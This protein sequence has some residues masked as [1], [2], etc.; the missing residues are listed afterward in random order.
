MDS[1]GRRVC[2]ITPSILGGVGEYPRPVRVSRAGGEI[3]GTLQSIAPARHLV[4]VARFA[5]ECWR[6]TFVPCRNFSVC[7]R[8][9]VARQRRKSV[10]F[11]AGARRPNSLASALP[12]RQRISANASQQIVTGRPE[13]NNARF[14]QHQKNWHHQNFGNRN[15]RPAPRHTRRK[16]VSVRR[17]LP[18]WSG[19]ATNGTP[20][21]GR[22]LCGI[23][24]AA[25]PPTPYYHLTIVVLQACASWATWRSLGNGR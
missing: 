20:D 23:G 19:I 1:I 14:D 15:A 9:R 2:A 7:S 3:A 22:A 11:V 6:L 17:R 8:Q 4:P 18:R 5:P 25:P 16:A 12:F 10:R 24:A 21:G 13:N